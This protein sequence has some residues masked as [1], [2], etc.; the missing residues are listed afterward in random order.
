M[1]AAEAL[2]TAEEFE[3]L[4]E[5]DARRELVQGRLIVTPSTGFEHGSIQVQLAVLIQP[6]LTRHNLGRLVTEV[7]AILARNPDT[8][9]GPDAA[10]YSFARIPAGT[11]PRGFP[12][13]L[14]ELVFEVRSPGDSWN[15]VMGKVHEYLRASVSVV[16][17]DPVP[18]TVH[19]FEVN[20]APRQVGAAGNFDLPNLWP[21]LTFPVADL[22][23]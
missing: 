23:V 4:P 15:E 3:Q 12:T 9:R 18:Q 14:P 7:G 16:V 19:I 5:A 8:V 22:F 20:Q 17:I 1:S 13:V 10:Y 6:H 21:G 2:M 11:R